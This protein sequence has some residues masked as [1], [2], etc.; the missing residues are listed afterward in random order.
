MCKQ[1][2][3]FVLQFFLFSLNQKSLV[4]GYVFFEQTGIASIRVY[5]ELLDMQH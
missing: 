4:K 2:C 5:D 3:E 1:S